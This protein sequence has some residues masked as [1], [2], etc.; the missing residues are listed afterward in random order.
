MAATQITEFTARTC[1][2]CGGAGRISSFQYIKGGECFRCGGSG[3]DPVMI[4]TTRDMTDDEVIAA[5][6]AAG[7]PVLFVERA[8]TGDY[9]K[10]LFLSEA[11]Q[12]EQEAAMQGA[13]MMLAAL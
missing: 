1:I 6:A 12:A 4:E 2:K 3:N 13:R 7:F 5:L 8:E 9:L 10:D 11:E